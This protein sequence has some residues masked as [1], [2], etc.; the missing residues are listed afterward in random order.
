MDTTYTPEAF[1]ALYDPAAE[2]AEPMQLHSRAGV[3]RILRDEAD[4]IARKRTD[5]ADAR[6][7]FKSRT[8]D[9]QDNRGPRAAENL[10]RLQ[11]THLP[12]LIEVETKARLLADV[13][14]KNLQSVIDMVESAEPEFS[15]AEHQAMYYRVGTVREDVETLPLARLVQ[16]ARYAVLT[17]DRVGQAL[18]ARYIPSRLATKSGTTWADSG[19]A[20]EA[21]QLRQITAHINESLRNRS[22]DD[23][24]TQAADLR[25]Q[26]QALSLDASK[27]AMQERAEQAAFVADGSVDW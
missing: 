12:D 15:A 9:H 1:G 7:V 13:A 19:M 2:Q 26:A 6:A 14:A 10:A 23:L 25:S 22:L 11:E 20:R 17:G 21:D 16:Q 18:L 4:R 3:E 8:E 5:I 24:R 27:R